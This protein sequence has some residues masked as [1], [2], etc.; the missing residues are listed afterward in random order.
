MAYQWLLSIFCKIKWTV[1]VAEE[2]SPDDKYRVVFQEREAPD[3]PFGSAHAR[4]IL[5]EGSQV[6][7]RFDEDVATDGVHFNE[8]H[9]SIY[10]KEDE[11]A[12]TFFG[13]QDPVQRVIPLED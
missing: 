4:V 7:E 8:Y 10:W 2:T 12:I 13:E 5:Y 3:W 9:Y 1:D 11:V 6:I